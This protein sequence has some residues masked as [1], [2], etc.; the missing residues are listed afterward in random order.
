MK[1]SKQL[2]WLKKNAQF[3]SIKA[4]EQAIG[5]PSTTIQQFVGK[6]QRPIPEKWTEPIE[7]WILNFKK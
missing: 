5:C 6:A 7:K 2:D 1:N 4:I 3:L